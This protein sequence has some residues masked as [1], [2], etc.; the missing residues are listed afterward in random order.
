MSLP[1]ALLVPAVAW[2]LLTDLLYRRINN[3]LVLWLLIAWLMWLVVGL[4]RGTAIDP[5]ALAMG[6]GSAFGIMCA[7][8]LLFLI[9]WMGGGDA[10]LMAV[11]CLW[12]GEQAPL[13]LM[14]TAIAGGGV[15]LGLPLVRRLEGVLGLLAMR[16]NT[17]IPGQP[18]PLPVGL[19]NAPPAGLPYAAA[20]ACGAVFV[21]WRT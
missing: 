1:F 11:L 4:V 2:A 17:C 21:L 6:F 8:Y 14:A 19:T 12:F 7:G 18:I 9:R 16:L 20:I 15:A 10:K 3:S 13:F 5:S